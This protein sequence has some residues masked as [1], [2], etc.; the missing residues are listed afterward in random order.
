A[1]TPS[2]RGVIRQSGEGDDTEYTE[3]FPSLP[4]ISHTHRHTHTHTCAHTHQHTHTPHTHTHH[5]PHRTHAHTH[6]HTHTHTPYR[7]Q[8]CTNR[9]L[10]VWLNREKVIQQSACLRT[11]PC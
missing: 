5:T 4:L 7:R 8:L 10:G 6:T 9:H 3:S 2:A 1:H 11:V